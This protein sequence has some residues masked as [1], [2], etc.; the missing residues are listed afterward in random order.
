[1]NP[2]RKSSLTLLALPLCALTFAGVAPSVA[3]AA[4]K[5]PTVASLLKAANAALLS[6]DSVHVKVSTI[7]GKVAS[8]VIADI[9]KTSGRES[10]HSGDESFT[11]SVT[12][13]YAYLSGSKEGLI[14]LMDLTEVEQQKVGTHAIAM[15]KGTS[16][17]TT[18][19]SNLTSSTFANLLPHAK[20]TTL[21]AK[22]DAATGGYQLSWHEAATSSSPASTTVI[23]ISAGKKAL[24][25][26]E[27]VTTSEGKSK[28]TFTQW[29]EAVKVTAP[30]STVSYTK[31]FPTSK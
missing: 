14:K 19:D 22:R 11:I 9:G 26:K 20:G 23:T 30:T 5:H 16:P 15:K 13:T 18:F 1:V 25:L 24:P 8:S 7:S 17:Y 27:S 6:E 28:T 12:P 3:N 2:L 10:Y 21:L 29:G 31:I 4:V